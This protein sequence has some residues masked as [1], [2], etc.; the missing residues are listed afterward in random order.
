MTRNIPT[1][2]RLET[3]KPYRHIGRVEIEIHSFIRLPVLLSGKEPPMSIKWEVEWA[4]EAVQKKKFV[5][6][7]NPI[8]IP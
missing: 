7:E 8:K 5:S 2:L 4:P 3:C 6:Y 1:C